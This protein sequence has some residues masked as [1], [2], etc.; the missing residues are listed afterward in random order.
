VLLLD[1]IES[2]LSRASRQGN[3]VAL[4]FVDLDGF[5][6]VNDT[7]GHRAGDQL[8]VAVARRLQQALRAEDTLARLAGDEFVV[9]CE[10]IEDMATIEAVAGRVVETL[11]APFVLDDG[12]AQISGSIGVSVATGHGDDVDQLLRDAD[13][14]MYRAKKSG[15]SRYEFAADEWTTEQLATYGGG[16]GLGAQ[17]RDQG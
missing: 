15:K 17:G 5:K 4:M 10:R 3:R 16:A 9:L 8:L 6:A 2:A 11:R 1:R 14:A 13:T 7:F 12:T